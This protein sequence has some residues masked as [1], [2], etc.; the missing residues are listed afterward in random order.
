MPT[1]IPFV[2]PAYTIDSLNI[3]CQR[4]LNW[5]PEID[6]SNSKSVL[7]LK[8]RPGLKLFTT[9]T[10]G[11]AIRGLYN[12]SND[13]F[14][15]V[16]G[17][18][19][20]EIYANG[21]AVVRGTIASTTGIVKMT[22][23]GIQLILVDG[24]SGSGYTLTFGGNVFAEITDA[25]YP[26]GT[27][28]AFI[29]QYFL[30]NKPN[31]QQYQWCDLADGT[32]WPGLNIAS[33]EGSP[34]Y[35]NS[36]ISLNGELWVF[37]PQS[38]EVHYNTGLSRGTFARI[39]GSNHGVG[40]IAPYSL[41]KSEN[42]VFWLGGDDGGWGR[43]YTNVGYQAQAIS[44]NAIDQVIQRYSKIDDAIGYCYQKLGHEFYQLSFPTPSVT[45]VFDISTGM[46]HE[47]SWTNSNN[48]SLMA[49]GIVQDFAFGEVF[50]GDW[51]SGSVFEVDPDT[52][53]DN[54]DLIHRERTSPHIWSN[55]DRN[56]YGSFQLDI[57][58]GI[59]LV[60]GQGEDPQIMLQISND[61]GHTYGSERWRGAGRL[62]EYRKRVKW[63]RLGTSRDRVWKIKCT[64]PVKWVILG[65]YIEA[66]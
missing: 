16:C 50:V 13:R 27:H 66:E 37:G 15:G 65:A 34:D 23:N 45:W 22:D 24:S 3:N 14:F 41:A 12:A 46:W 8:P 57:E 43:V 32:S 21:S 25:G 26:G 31:T 47:E 20:S 61:G 36:L 51:R 38:Y 62:G 58:P 10:G 40:N 5:Y 11:G 6:S 59:G 53:T 42:N 7:S 1:P 64:D 19:L 30:S 54:G 35:N 49:R 28:V 52:Y 44:T 29:D 39:Q 18:T 56:F 9:L 63:N 2:G 33:S 4:C 60:S 17:N 55:L 48:D